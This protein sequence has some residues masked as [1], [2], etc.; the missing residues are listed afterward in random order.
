VSRAAAVAALGLLAAS[1]AAWGVDVRAR[2]DG[3]EFAKR[4]ELAARRPEALASARLEPSADQ[5]AAV[6]ASTAVEDETGAVKW[7]G[8]TEGEREAWMRSLEKRDELLGAAR[9]LALGAAAARPGWAPHR[10]LAARL[11]F[12]EERRKGFPGPAERWLAPLRAAG[13]EAPSAAG[14][15]FLAAAMLESWPS[16]SPAERLE[17]P[18][19]LEGALA[20]PAGVAR[21]LPAAV[22]ALGAG[23]AA[24]LVPEEPRLLKALA[25]ERA[26]AGDLAGAEAA[27]KRYD[28]A[29]RKARAEDLAA[30]ERRARMKDLDGVRRLCRAWASRHPAREDDGE[31]GRRQAARV[32][33]LWPADVE[34]DFRR[35]G[36]GELVRYFLEGREAFV[37]GEALRRAVT[38][39]REV[40]EVVVARAALLAGDRYAWERLLEGSETAGTLEWTPFHVDLARAEL[41]AGRLREARAALGRIATAARTECAVLLARREVARAERRA[42]AAP[43]DDEAEI[44]AALSRT[45]WQLA[46]VHALSPRGAVPVCV[47][48]EEDAKGALKVRLAVEGPALLAWG[49]NDGVSAKGLVTGEAEVEAP[50]A[51]LQGRA[52]FSTRV[53]AGGA[54]RLVSAAMEEEGP[55]SWRLQAVAASEAPTTQASVA[56]MAGMERLNSTKP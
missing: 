23:E 29:E 34:G 55:S 17:L 20:D 56:G 7:N 28:A 9:S 19:A 42:G 30:I 24:R 33:E 45:R 15:A 43:G 41:A 53:L 31:A 3:E 38:A 4:Y 2:R 27:W 32:L 52:F 16:L 12:L 26:R 46:E 8:L 5:A 36:R 54:P 22:A 37:S 14:A 1:V 40:P 47:D 13:K 25:G 50:L 48:P 51:G 35:D 39:L 18:R 49:W 10:E 44:A 11:T 6:L 21:L